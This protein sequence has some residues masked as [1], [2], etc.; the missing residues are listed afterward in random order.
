MKH[1]YDS[2]GTCLLIRYLFIIL[3][4]LSFTAGISRA[5]KGSHEDLPEEG[6]I[7]TK[8]N[9]EKQ[10]LNIFRR[11]F[12]SRSYDSLKCHENIYRLL[13]KAESEKMD[14]TDLNVIFIFNKEHDKLMPIKS[15]NA[16]DY[17][18]QRPTITMH[19][20]RIVFN[21]SDPPGQFR[22]HVFAAFKDKIMDFDYTNSP[23]MLPAQEY[24]NSMFA[25]EKM[26]ADKR[27]ELFEGLTLR[28]ISAVE[29]LQTYPQHTSWYLFDLE[30]RFPSQSA[31]DYIRSL[32]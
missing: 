31:N 29:Y 6:S 22:Y 27:R 3:I 4:F 7:K 11:L 19:R 18:V 1:T 30:N 14:L 17:G 21:R 25:A 2:Y 20:T 5:E 13:K 28:I 32:K 15:Q 9:L 10:Y 23:K 24:F 16:T 26:S 8:K 12:F